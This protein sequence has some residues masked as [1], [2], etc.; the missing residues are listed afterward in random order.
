MKTKTLLFL[1]ALACL[2][3]CLNPP[4]A[5]NAVDPR[6]AREI[7]KA[8]ERKVQGTPRAVDEALLASGIVSNQT[9]REALAGFLLFGSIPAPSTVV[10]GIECL[11]PGHYLVAELGG[12]RTKRYWDFDF[13]P[14]EGAG[15]AQL[16]GV[17]RDAVERH[18]PTGA[19]LALRTAALRAKRPGGG[20]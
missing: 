2:G 15:A 18:L 1:G 10:Q 17:L 7:D 13:S 12:V 9:N 11:L 4:L 19:L 16:G 6:I 3:G 14:S 5:P 20:G 8:G